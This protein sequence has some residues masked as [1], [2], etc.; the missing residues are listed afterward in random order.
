M[1]YT[2]SRGTITTVSG[3]IFSY[4][5][6]HCCGQRLYT[7]PTYVEETVEDLPKKKKKKKKKKGGGSF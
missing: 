6:C 7:N 1:T 2:C 5:D 4:L 3:E